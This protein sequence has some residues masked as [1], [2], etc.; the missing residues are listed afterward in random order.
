MAN[1]FGRQTVANVLVLD[2]DVSGGVNS[3]LTVYKDIDYNRGIYK[4]I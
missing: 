1:G 3:W 4:R 2:W